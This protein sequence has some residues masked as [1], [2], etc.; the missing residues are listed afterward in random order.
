MR[1]GREIKASSP[2]PSPLEE[3]ENVPWKTVNPNGAVAIGSPTKPQPLWG[4]NPPP[5]HSQGSSFL[6]T[7]GWRTQS[8]WDWF[9]KEA[10]RDGSRGNI[11]WFFSVQV[12]SLGRFKL[13]IVADP[14]NPPHA[15]RA[16]DSSRAG[17]LRR[18]GPLTDTCIP[19]PRLSEAGPH[20]PARDP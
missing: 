5:A 9:F 2:R 17:G 19:G 7:L 11:F 15:T 14:L 10:L 12:R 3:R 13:T 8:R 20:S 1:L 16:A 18:A 4:R 6:A